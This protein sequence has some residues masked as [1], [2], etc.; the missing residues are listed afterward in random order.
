M[1]RTGQAIPDS[2]IYRVHHQHHR[3]PHEV[4]LLAGYDFPRCEKCSD[5]VEFEGVRLAPQ[6]E[7]LRSNIVLYALPV[8]G[9]D[10]SNPEAA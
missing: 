10:D 4:T 2:G 9:T 8:M 5:P 7:S 6:P 3:L 1:Y